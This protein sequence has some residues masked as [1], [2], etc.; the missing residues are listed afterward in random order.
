MAPGLPERSL[1]R[2][3]SSRRLLRAVLCLALAIPAAAQTRLTLEQASS[4]QPPDY[5]PAYEGKEIVVQ[6]EVPY[7]PV[8]IVEFYHLHIQDDTYH[9]LTLEGSKEQFDGITAGDVLE[10]RGVLGNRAGLPVLVPSSI[11]R[12]TSRPAP[13]PQR[14]RL[15][16]LATFRYLGVLVNTEGRIIEKGSNEGGEFLIVTDKSGTL[17]AYLPKMALGAR[18]GF[19]QLHVGDKVRLAGVAS[20]YCT[21]PPYNTGFELLVDDP[22]AV[23]MIEGGSFLPPLVLVTIIAFGAISFGIWRIRENRLTAQRQVTKTLNAL[24]EEILGAGSESDILKRLLAVL[25]KATAVTGVR[26]YLY[27]KGSRSIERVTS[28][29]DPVPFVVPLDAPADPVSSGAAICFK[30]RTLLNIPDTRRSPFFKPNLAL[31]TPRSMM[32]IP[33]LAQAECVGV[34]ELDHGN[35]MRFF[36]RD[37]QAATQHLANQ[38]AT[39]LKLREQA[40]MR[41]QLLHTEKLAATGQL[42]AG[43]A[44]ELR[45]PLRA[46]S[47]LADLLIEHSVVPMAERELRA[48]VAEARRAAEIVEHLVSFTRAEEAQA[49]TIDLH[50]LLSG[51]VEFRSREWVKRGVQVRNRIPA[52]GGLLVIGSQSQLEQVFLNLLV[53]AE[54][55]MSGASEQTLTLT[56]AQLGRRALVEIAFTETPEQQITDPFQD[57]RDGMRASLGLGVCRGIIHSHGGEIRLVRMAGLGSRF[58]VELP[59]AASQPQETSEPEEPRRPAS[60]PLTVLLVEPENGVQRQLVASLSERGHRVVPVSSA[61]EGAELVQ[62]LRFDL[63]FCSVR[64][65][66]SSWLEF[67]ERVRAKIGSFVLLTEGYNGELSRAFQGGNGYLLAKPVQELELS[68]LLNALES[69]QEQAKAVTLK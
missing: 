57:A 39:A 45:A 16:Q 9:G 22:D 32:F 61:E 62:R 1:S 56:T 10:V 37:E 36:N 12:L 33:M 18:P 7:R 66:S 20:Q 6:G 38:I 4:R 50:R 3:I 60:R 64:L 68:R 40:N 34:L 67:F 69:R 53:H 49:K 31:E 8:Q 17:K 11:A 44:D 5:A 26:L 43:V 41:E 15:D 28:S 23:A 13:A 46:I 30:N 27:R 48:I 19:A 54:Q 47:T 25:P 2:R 58:E 35:G 24:G 65:P 59:L 52:T 63:V 51:L 14:Y 55:S 21:R 29:Q 42:I